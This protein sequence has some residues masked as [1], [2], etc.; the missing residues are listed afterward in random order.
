MLI[1]KE[2]EGIELKKG[3]RKLLPLVLLFILLFNLSVTA[4]F[5]FETTSTS[6]SALCPRDTGLF[7]NVVENQNSFSVPFTLTNRGS[8]SSWSTT[9]PSG[10]TLA[11]HER[12]TIYTYITPTQNALPGNYDV[13]V[14]ASGAGQTKTARFETKVKDC[15]QANLGT[16]D[17]RKT[18]C[19]AQVTKF[20]SRLRNTGQYREDYILRV[21]GQLKDFVSLSED[22]VSLSAEES[23]KVFAY[24]TAPKE[25][26]EYGFSIV[27]QGSSGRS[28]QSLNHILVV[29]P[30]YDFR[31]DV[32][33]NTF[34]FCERA[35]QIV[36]LKVN[37][38][39][40]TTNTYTLALEG[41]SWAV[42]ERDAVTL[43]AGNSATVNLFLNPPFG[44]EGDFKV[45]LSVTPERGTRKAVT[46]FH[47]NVKKCHAVDITLL[48]G[49]K[50]KVCNN[51][52]ERSFDVLIRNS[53][54]VHKQYSFEQ[55][56]PRWVSVDLPKLFTLEA[57]KERKT[58]IK[59]N[60]SQ[61]VKPGRYDTHLKVVATDESAVTVSD[62]AVFEV[63]TVDTH[64]CYK[65]VFKTQY[66]DFVVYLDSSVVLP[67]TIQNIGL[68]NA[69][70]EIV[71][72]GSAASFSKL[73][74]ATISVASGRSEVVYVYIA[75]GAQ[76]KLT[77][78][79]LQ[80]S[81]KLKDSNLLETERLKL[82][83]TNIKE[84]A[85]PLEQLQ[86]KLPVS[87]APSLWEKTKTWFREVFAPPK[88][89]LAL[90]KNVKEDNITK[91]KSEGI[92]V[93]TGSTT[94]ELKLKENVYKY[95][96]IL[97]GGSIILLLGIIFV[98][99]DAHKKIV[100]FFGKDDED[101]E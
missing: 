27:A 10:F 38:L 55:Q 88:R 52:R 14:I 13:E 31:L 69:D 47:V 81:V 8:A 15:F 65:P 41:S 44:V 33:N 71:V 4:T 68:E 93:M 77:N 35:T 84:E 51:G 94:K 72:G 60:P 46:E 17:E 32:A 83:L 87:I 85:T 75:P 73:V 2:R 58:T 74:P 98:R 82:R 95:R 3:L 37:N 22:V 39:G 67:V 30:C 101:D 11:P 91:N 48:E 40:T 9:V 62:T 45:K 1:K 99:T 36:P 79:D 64:E 25:A 24:I 86:E 78:Y 57:G 20:E 97:L 56:G 34:K 23:K 59:T 96:Y 6:S 90:S 7:V 92:P 66:K 12:K 28:V 54:E 63:E 80:L 5:T 19:P 26:G 16:N 76:T 49:G 43:L 50:V 18:V 89:Q 29:Q 61:D 21:E 70:Y 100:G 53:G 42:L